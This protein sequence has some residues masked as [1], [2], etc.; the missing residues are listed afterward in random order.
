MFDAVLGCVLLGLALIFNATLV[1]WSRKTINQI[2]R[3]GPG[4]VH[5]VMKDLR[6][7]G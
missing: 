7:G 5:K 1:L 2:H 6:D 4:P 3:M